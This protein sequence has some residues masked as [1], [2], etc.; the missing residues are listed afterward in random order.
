LKSLSDEIFNLI[1]DSD[2]KPTKVAEMVGISGTTLSDLKESDTIGFISMLKIAQ[3]CKGSEYHDVMRKWCQVL[4]TTESL[5]HA[6]EYAAVKRDVDLL[7]E[8]LCKT[9]N[10]EYLDLYRSVYGLIYSFMRGKIPF[11]DLYNELKSV[12]T[13]K[14]KSLSI[15]V[16]IYNCY[17]LYYKKDFLGILTRAKKIEKEI[18]KLGN[19]RRSF[20]KQCYTYRL[21]E[22]MMPVHLHFSNFEAARRY[23]EI[24]IHS[25]ISYKALSDGYY[26][27]G[28][29]YLLSNKSLC[30]RYLERSYQAMSK[31][32][33]TDLIAETKTNFELAK[34]YF[35]V[36][37]GMSIPEMKRFL[38]NMTL[39]DEADFIKYFGFISKNSLS[40]IY[41]GI[42]YFFSKKNFLFAYLIADDLARFG[43]DGEQVEALKS[44]KLIDKVEISF[45]K[46]VISCFNHWDRVGISRV[47]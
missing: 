33:R 14:D 40:S 20:F 35:D 9:K 39:R 32:E 45:E 7:G 18:Q 31:I 43:V 37:E 36:R 16:N 30:L 29:S 17:M 24:L 25:N 1:E 34:L 46:E 41:E 47:S 6:F 10:D 38:M 15:I 8:L 11:L 26:G 42:S 28:M 2:L 21:S 44:I 22:V 23:A 27:L 5:K 12:R 19:G 3:V 13:S 4:F